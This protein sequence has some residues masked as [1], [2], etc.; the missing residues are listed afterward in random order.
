MPRYIISNCPQ[1]AKRRILQCAKGSNPES[2]IRPLIIDT[3]LTDAVS[4]CH[5]QD[6][7]KARSTLLKYV[8]NKPFFISVHG[9]NKSLRQERRAVSDNLLEPVQ[10]TFSAL[11]RISRSWHVLY[12]N[13]NDLEE[14][15]AFVLKTQRVHVMLH[16]TSARGRY[17][18]PNYA[19]MEYLQSRNQIWKRWVSNYNAR[20]QIRINL[21]FNLASQGDNK[22]NIEIANTSKKIS[23][24]TLRDSSS[25]ITIATMTMI[26]LPGTFVSVRRCPTHVPAIMTELH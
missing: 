22:V 3:Y 5:N 12:E 20:T 10:F 15:M 14:T 2:L 26:F 23:E 19:A 9:C 7:E 13:L 21:H 11:H 4:E 16:A 24:A 18:E 1:N 25:M 8:S 6:L 17:L